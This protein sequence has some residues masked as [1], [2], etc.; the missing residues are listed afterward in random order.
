MSC[1][2]MKHTS[3]IWFD[4]M[5]MCFNRMYHVKWPQHRLSAG[6][7]WGESPVSL[8]AYTLVWA[9]LVCFKLEARA[10]SGGTTFIRDFVVVFFRKICI[11]FQCRLWCYSISWSAVCLGKPRWGAVWVKRYSSMSPCPGG[12]VLMILTRSKHVISRM[13]MRPWR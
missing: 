2:I 5:K 8:V 12:S 7:M 9:K 13:N 10:I 11:W 1:D 3:S 6:H 4:W